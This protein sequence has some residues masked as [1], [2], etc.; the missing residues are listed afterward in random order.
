MN[1]AEHRGWRLEATGG[2]G[3]TDR[4]A[5]SRTGLA[6]PGLVGRDLQVRRIREFLLRDPG[7]LVLEGE[8]GIGKSRLLH[9]AV[10]STALTSR[11]VLMAACPPVR[12]PFTLG[13]VVDALRQ[14]RSRV[15]GLGWSP[16]AG[17]LRS[18]IPEWADDL[19]PTPERADDATASRHRLFRAV[20]EALVLLQVEVLAVDDVHWADDATVEFLLF[21]ASQ[22]PQ[23]A[24]VIVTFRPEEV[25]GSSA[26]RG[27]SRLAAGG[28]DLRLV[29]GPLGATET[30]Q[31]VSS[32]VDGEHVS[33]EF[34]AF[35]FEHTDGV[36]LVVEESMRLLHDRRDLV[37]RDGR[38]ERRELAEIQVPA[39]VRD[40]V[41][42]RMGRLEPLAQEVLRAAAVLAGPADI[43]TLSAVSEL[44]GNQ[45]RQ[46]V[47][48]AVRRGFLDE[49]SRGQV[50]FRHMLVARTIYE[51]I[52]RVER[53]PLHLLAG[54]A[55]EATP[56]LHLRQLARH[57]RAAHR[58]VEWCRYAEQ[59]ADVAVSSDDHGTAIDLLSVLLTSADLPPRDRAR[60]AAKLAA[61]VVDR[62]AGG[63]ALAGSVVSTLRDVVNDESLTTRERAVIH[64]RL[65]RIITQSNQP[66]DDRAEIEDAVPLLTDN[67]SEAA[68][69]MSVL[70]WPRA[71]LV[72]AR[73][74]IG[75]LDRVGAIETSAMPRTERV[76]IAVT[77]ATAL[78]ILGQ[79]RGWDIGSEAVGDADTWHDE[80]QQNAAVW[81]LNS[82][83]QEALRGRLESAG[84]R[85][86]RSL[87][88][89]DP[90]HSARIRCQILA[91][92]CRLDWQTGSW[93]GLTRRCSDLRGSPDIEPAAMLEAWLVS[94]LLESAAGS[95][96]PPL[97]ELRQVLEE[98]E[99]RGILDL[100]M[101][102][103][104]ALGR[105]LL[106]QDEIDEA[107]HVT[108][109]ATQV[110]LAK[111]SWVWGSEIVPV[112]V[113]A[114]C[115]AGREAEAAQLDAAMRTGLAG[116]DWPAPEAGSL[117]SQAIL[118]WHTGDAAHAAYLSERAATAWRGL[119]RPYDSLLTSERHAGFLL[120]L[121]RTD[122][123]VTELSDI[124][125]RLL[126][127]GASRD[128]DRL[129]QT[130]RLHG[131]EARR[132]SR[133][134]RRGYGDQLS[135]R[136]LEVVRLVAEGRT[137]R[138]IADALYRSPKTVSGQ[139][140][141]AMRKLGVS[142]RTALA[143]A[144][145]EASVLDGTSPQE[146]TDVQDARRS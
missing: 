62:P 75:W 96:D 129:A 5:A 63:S 46:A 137:N 7:V 90:E 67:P 6:V 102:P 33:D 30:A 21:L 50:H 104:A 134:G 114:L 31:M 59:A 72:P 99:R 144:A 39:T 128:A 110:L 40:S 103:A 122:E 74:L 116:R 130:L 66:A 14:R 84:R 32:M 108:E 36:P 73:E 93:E 13:P 9:E 118:A 15:E 119:P 86:D 113:D 91:D 29:L 121:G 82:G 98:V 145:A 89:A 131:A 34:A 64:I 106:A 38:W 8:T 81:L 92:R 109:H 69:A 11:Q 85:L 10:A 87:G 127:L 94:I 141:A 111:D 136:E 45:T 138:E 117:L 65:G 3:V 60:V 123:A 79:E 143:L 140:Q 2:V 71:D 27:L 126:Q 58:P 115:R 52:P 101:E 43:E 133:R 41:L 53:P 51:D 77:R 107:L 35:L 88:L 4:N 37:N 48:H 42:E 95:T 19:P 132:P 142:S 22:R 124:F 54:R 135:P 55:L 56:H 112:R 61:A 70:G 23:R 16:L 28:S 18:L 44:S 12:E 139:L 17:V 100:Q 76:S 83:E 68:R 49:D 57:F 1:L 20:V 47:V 25:P 80:D 105:L 97:P 120:A 125:H 26:I 78:L 24:G 146:P